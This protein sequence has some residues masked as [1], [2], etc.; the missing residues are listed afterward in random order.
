VTI[1]NARPKINLMLH[2]TERQS[3]GFHHLQSLITFAGKG[4]QI[5]T[6]EKD[7]FS[8]DIK[9]P[10]G[11][12]LPIEDNL[13]LK[14]AKWISDFYPSRS[15]AHITLIKNLPVSSG[16]GGGSSDAATT[17]AAL[18]DMWGLKLE[19]SDKQRL[20]K[21]SGELGA[22]VPV[23]LAHHLLKKSYFWIDGSG[24]EGLPKPLWTENP[25]SEYSI[26]LV[27]PKI[28][29]STPEIFR[30]YDRMYD[31]PLTPPDNASMLMDFLIKT[32]NSLTKFVSEIVPEIGKILEALRSS[33]DC[34]LA[35]MSGSGAT[36]FGIYKNAQ[37]CESAASKMDPNW[38]VSDTISCK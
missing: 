34:Q 31:Q 32:K 29:V 25:L 21:K 11:S 10:F 18:I 38:W 14:A 22:D 27:N 7:I 36:C 37:A 24:K 20:I 26:L 8:L 33:G 17:I 30:I 35:R 16:I 4:D 1:H 19:E 12:I 23:C 3:S 9:G 2:I 5:E 15:K 13:V 28:A 6:Q